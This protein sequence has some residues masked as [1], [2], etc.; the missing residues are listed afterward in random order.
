MLSVSALIETTWQ[1]IEANQPRNIAN[2]PLPVD[3]CRAE[4]TFF[5]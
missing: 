5:T 3:V 1:K 4:T 2:S